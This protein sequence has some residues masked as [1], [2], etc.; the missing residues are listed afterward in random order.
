M[1]KFWILLGVLVLFG[2]MFGGFVEG[3]VGVL[4]HNPQY[5]S[6]EPSKLNENS[7]AN[8][9]I[10]FH[11]VGEDIKNFTIEFNLSNIS[12]IYDDDGWDCNIKNV[13]RLYCENKTPPT[14][15]VNLILGVNTPYLG[16]DFYD[17]IFLN[18]TD[19]SNYTTYNNVS[20]LIY[21]DNESPSLSNSFPEWTILPNGTVNFIFTFFDNE[22]GVSSS[23]GYL[24]YS[25]GDFLQ[26]GNWTDYSPINFSCSLWQY[27]Y[28]NCS[29]TLNFNYVRFVNYRI[30]GVKDNVGN[31]YSEG[32]CTGGYNIIHHLY[33]DAEKPQINL[34]NPDN[35]KNLNDITYFNF[36]VY[37]NSFE[38]AG[39]GNF[40]PMINCSIIINN[41]IKNSTIK[42]VLS[43]TWQNL[44]LSYNVSSLPDGNYTWHV[45]C[46]DAAGWQSQS[47]TRWFVVDSHGPNIT[48]IYPDGDYVK[49]NVTFIW[50][51]S[52]ISEPINC[53]LYVDNQK[54]GEVN[55]KSSGQFNLTVNNLQDGL[56][57]WSV[58]CWDAT[59][60]NSSSDVWWFTVDNST[61][62][63]TIIQP[64]KNDANNGSYSGTGSVT[65]TFNFTAFDDKT[66]LTCEWFID[67]VKDNE[68]NITNASYYNFS[69]TFTQSGS[70][71]WQVNCKDEAGNIGSDN[72]SFNVQIQTSSGGGGGAGGGG[73][74][75]VS[76]YN[77]C[78]YGTRANINGTHYKVC[79]NYDADACYEWKTFVCPNGTIFLNGVCQNLKQSCQELWKCDAW[80]PCI[81]GTQTRSCIDIN[82]CGTEKNKPI[83]QQSCEVANE[84]ALEEKT[85][86]KTGFNLAGAAIG[87]VKKAWL[88]AVIALL[89]ILGSYFGIKAVRK[90]REKEE[91]EIKEKVQQM[92]LEKEIGAIE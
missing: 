13:K 19:I 33:I 53:S 41:D 77:E 7:S 80:G 32:S 47:E 8:L 4:W 81:N 28:Y 59:G 20:Y 23:S 14:N 2:F 31:E 71:T 9:S 27:D 84:T 52:D 83:T 50:N 70:H 73:G 1:R 68:T 22:S 78:S 10:V 17:V 92:L 88:P 3:Q 29:L 6:T 39:Q 49:P 87:A 12:S 37:D 18:L 65:I 36:S 69:K 66:N 89:L 43:N 46:V 75:S 90:R 72:A 60:K 54:E 30:E 35:G 48:L 16:Y 57:N 34:T 62:V 58:T 63:V 45:S 91:R 44:S 79:G 55:N 56:H 61:P 42:S 15:I 86:S 76:C 40:Q 11:V 67:G 5:I 24:A 25:T 51:A 64:S 85:Q 38:T 82:N 74:G 21:H 26:C